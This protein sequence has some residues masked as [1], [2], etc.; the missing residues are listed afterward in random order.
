A[1]LDLN[2]SR[3]NYRLSHLRTWSTPTMSTE[4]LGGSILIPALPDSNPL[5]APSL[6]IRG[7]RWLHVPL[8]TIGLLGVS[9]LWS[10]EMSYGE[11]D[12]LV[13]KLRFYV[14]RGPPYLLSLGLSPSL[15]AIVFLAGPLSGF[16]VQPIIGVVADNSTSA[17]GRRRPYMIAGSLVSGAAMLVL[18]FTRSVSDVLFGARSSDE[19]VIAL[20]VIAIW[21]ADFSINVVQS[22]DRALIV[23]VL[24][25][26][27]Q[28]SATGWAARMMC[29]GSVIGFFVGNLN[30]PSL[31]PFFGSSELQILS[32][33]VVL[34]TVLGHATTALM[35]REEAFARPDGHR[36]SFIAELKAIFSNLI[37]LPPVILRICLIQFCAWLGWFPLHF[38]TTM[39]IASLY[40]PSE[41]GRTPEEIADEGT[42]LGARALFQSAAL[43]LIANLILPFFIRSTGA[44]DALSQAK[45]PRWKFPLARLWQWSH[46]FFAVCM[47]GTF[48]I[49]SMDGAILLIS[50]SGISYAVSMWAP[51]ALLGEAILDDESGDA[52]LSAK[53]GVI[54]GIHNLFIV[55]PQFL[56]SLLCAA[57]FA[58]FTPDPNTPG[59]QKKESAVVYIFQFAGIWACVAF[60][61]CR[62]LGKRIRLPENP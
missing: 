47:L 43:T 13:R 30:L 6:P 35:V 5:H 26:E 34:L 60:Y 27:M 53:A 4:V 16:I 23:D 50:L 21:V 18:G 32:V 56:V 46:A 41:T 29:I 11:L 9:I 25:S 2:G 58:V 39:Y 42:R 8:L 33:F 57:I 17:W 24:P 49:T 19:T 28:A 62:K 22:M 45:T 15:V 40:S 59:R 3:C 36:R 38:Y 1:P 37:T 14:P 44:T 51:F 20:A 52:E 61:L 12:R 31:F 54:L 55:V 48:F 10:V 7:P